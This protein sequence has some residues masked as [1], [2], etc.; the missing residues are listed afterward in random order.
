MYAFDEII[1]TNFQDA[2]TTT[3]Y[4]YSTPSLSGLYTTGP[5]TNGYIWMA[6]ENEVGSA[7]IIRWKL[8]ADGTVST[9]DMGTV[10][11]PATNTSPLEMA[12]RDLLALDTQ[13][14]HLHPSQQVT[15]I[16]CPQRLGTNPIMCFP[17]YAG[18]PETNALWTA[19]A[20]DTNLIYEYGIAVDQSATFV[21]IAARGG[22]DPE[23]GATGGLYLYEASNGL[24]LTNLDQTGGDQYTDVA[25]DNVGNLY[26]LDTFA[27]VWRAYSPSGSN[28]ATTVSVPFIQAYNVLTP[29]SLWNPNL[30]DTG[31]NFTLEGQSNVTYYI[32]QSSD[33]V[34]WTDVTTNYS[35]STSR[36]ISIPFADNQD[37]YRAVTGH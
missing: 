14:P 23:I 8:L 2:V 29:P 22:G 30:S 25:W 20:G 33:L 36:T 4:P 19:G 34:T 17:P 12:A 28:Q 24:Y 37:F 1:S 13:W 21:A 31:L 11:C 27:N 15:P 35:P 6:D 26:A 18:I 5:A 16:G 3:N 10:I 32:Q 9:N 7:G